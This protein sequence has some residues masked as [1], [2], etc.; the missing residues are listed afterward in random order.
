VST[1]V[2]VGENERESRAQETPDDSVLAH[3]EVKVPEAV[4]LAPGRSQRRGCQGCQ[5]YGNGCLT[6]TGHARCEDLDGWDVLCAER[7][8]ALNERLWWRQLP[9]GATGLWVLAVMG[10][11][12]ENGHG[13]GD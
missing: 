4:L 13:R 3:I 10:R 1:A 11:M 7:D 2:R 8:G 9:R 12:K 5:F 6:E